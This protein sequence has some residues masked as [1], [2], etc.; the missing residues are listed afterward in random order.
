MNELSFTVEDNKVVPS[1]TFVNSFFVSDRM[2][3]RNIVEVKTLTV[4]NLIFNA[5]RN[6]G[7]VLYFRL[8]RLLYICGFVDISESECFSRKNFTVHCFITLNKR[9]H[10]KN[11]IEYTRG[12]RSYVE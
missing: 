9:R 12:L 5:I 10:R 8:I 7:K 1:K 11:N 3:D 4:S 2:I 6:E